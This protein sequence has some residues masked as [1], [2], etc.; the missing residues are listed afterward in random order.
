M[1]QRL[2]LLLQRQPRVR[3]GE[4]G[5]VFRFVTRFVDLLILPWVLDPEVLWIYLAARFASLS[6]PL[7]LNLLD[8]RV[9]RELSNL[10]QIRDKSRFQS[11]AA[12]VNICYLLVC[13]A[14]GVFVIVGAPS[15]A[16][17]L[18]I[19]AT[20]FSAILT[21]LVIGQSAPVLFGATSLLMHAVERGAFSDSL[22]GLTSLLFLIAVATSDMRD[23]VVIAQT[24]VAAQLTQ[25][26][27]CALLLTQCGVWPGA[28][29]LLHK[30]IKLF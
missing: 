20:P 8:A 30:E 16:I 10:A 14:M 28:T 3:G 5:G 19:Q 27:L 15:C 2:R 7:I 21:W 4:W 1:G 13:G 9:A 6:I 29:S 26:G 18:G 22:L 17:I 24:L 25:A 12:R 23:G 11:A